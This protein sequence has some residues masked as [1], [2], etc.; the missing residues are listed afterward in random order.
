MTDWWY[1]KNG[2]KVGPKS[3]D[4]LR[5]LFLNGKIGS[6][7]HVWRNGME[8]WSPIHSVS[9]MAQFRLPPAPPEPPPIPKAP[10]LEAFECPKASPW[11]RFFA[12][13]FDLWVELLVVSFGLGFGLSYTVPGFADW[14]DKPGMPALFGLICVPIAL[15]VDAFIARLFGNTPGKALLGIY[16]LD[17]DK[18]D[19]AE[20][21]GFKTYTKRNFGLWVE[22]M[23][24][25]LPFLNLVAFMVQYKRVKNGEPATYDQRSRRTVRMVT[26][27]WLKTAVFVILFLVVCAIQLVLKE[28]EKEDQRA[29]FRESYRSSSQ[30][31]A[32][33]W[34]NPSTNRTT[35]IPSIWSVEMRSPVEGMLYQFS[36][37]SGQAV[38]VIGRQDFPGGTIQGYADSF[39]QSN[40]ETI[41]LSAGDFRTENSGLNAWYSSG[42]SVSLQ[43]STMDV[44]VKQLGS[45]FWRVVTLQV[46][47]TSSSDAVV[48]EIKKQL[49]ATVPLR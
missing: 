31:G 4:E 38:A 19:Q 33:T 41:D 43:G 36:L 16:V 14:L 22:G 23:F 34:I 12:R 8:A 17:A 6:E 24:L 21:L 13:I 47:P 20:R 42:R 49:W 27:H 35:V 44:E 18:N 29:V 45:S 28:M 48:K 30:L 7:T 26:N 11:R 3:F 32:F 2:K 9:E 39:R 40:K 5:V 46:A 25:S 1:A 37:K 10:A 15:I